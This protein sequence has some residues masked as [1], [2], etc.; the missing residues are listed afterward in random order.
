MLK[1]TPF[2]L[3]NSGVFLFLFF[4]YYF[5]PFSMNEAHA[6]GKYILIFLFRKKIIKSKHRR[7]PIL[8]VF[9]VFF[10]LTFKTRL[11]SVAKKY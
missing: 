1:N 6:K 11:F 7:I 2:G 8:L 3:E 5:F 9:L 10:Q 4:Y